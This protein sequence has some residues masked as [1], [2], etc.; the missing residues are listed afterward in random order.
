MKS[1]KLNSY[2]F[3]SPTTL[4][5]VTI[6]FLYSIYSLAYATYISALGYKVM[7]ILWLL[8]TFALFLENSFVP[9]KR[10]LALYVSFIGLS[11]ASVFFPAS[12]YIDINWLAEAILKLSLSSM[13]VICF[14]NTGKNFDPVLKWGLFS[15]CV[16]LLL[17]IILQ[18]TLG[19]SLKEML[20][21]FADFNLVWHEWNRKY[22]SFWVLFLSWGTI[23]L[24]WKKSP[25]D[26]FLAIAIMILAGLAI[27]SDYSDSARV[28]FIFSLIVFML[29]HI[30]WSKWFI[31]WN[32]MI[33]LYIF[34]LPLAWSLMAT[35]GWVDSI[36]S[37]Q[38]LNNVDFRVDVYNFSAA[39]VSKQWFTGYGF[40]STLSILR[41]GLPFDTGGHPHNIVFLFWLELGLFGAF[42]LFMVTT[43]LLSFIHQS[44]YNQT[45]SPSAWAL[46]SSGLVIFSFSFDIW[47]TDIVLTYCM[48]LAM[49]MLSCQYSSSY[50]PD[51]SGGA[52]LT[53][54][55]YGL[56]IITTIG[57]ASYITKDIL[58]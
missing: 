56:L 18:Q 37:I 10:V 11:S 12:E 2:S 5:I 58:F 24:F 35:S 19:I 17:M 38:S 33:G 26:T 47:V 16:V 53:M 28:A 45:N 32:S 13:I 49:I 25:R 3:F 55:H 41:L 21:E 23:S 40:G 34:L 6:V 30:K 14:V 57:I 31:F 20:P 27:F 8:A 42:L 50:F 4:S 9:S 36:K 46:F 7:L 51:K 22:Y 52:K 54:F 48:W 1:V 43:T 15:C 39:E 29:A 44:T